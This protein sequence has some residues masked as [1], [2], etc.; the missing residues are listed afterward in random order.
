L[1]WR[2]ERNDADE[3]RK[4]AVVDVGEEGCFGDA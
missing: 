3:D 1:C 4:E 2:R